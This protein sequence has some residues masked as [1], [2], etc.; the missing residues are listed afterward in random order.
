M[1]STIRV[2]SSHTGVGGHASCP[3]G[4]AVTTT[5]RDAH[6]QAVTHNNNTHAG[7]FHLSINF[8]PER[9]V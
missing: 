2:R 3:C 1:N 7:A 4:W 9:S 6:E 5:K 8:A